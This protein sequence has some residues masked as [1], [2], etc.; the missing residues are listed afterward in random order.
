MYNRYWSIFTLSLVGIILSLLIIFLIIVLTVKEKLTRKYLIASA[1]VLIFIIFLCVCV[2]VPYAK[3]YKYVAN[4]TFFEDD[5]VVVE[6]TNVYRDLDG[7]GQMVYLEPKFYIESKDKYIVLDVANV[8]VGK[9][10]RI[11]YLPN[12]KICEILYCIE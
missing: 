6:F 4:G 11:R 5:A 8:E 1:A 12:T 3:D 9:K 2:I 7:N 10:Y